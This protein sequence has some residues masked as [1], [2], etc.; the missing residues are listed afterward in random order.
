MGLR[1]SNLNMSAH[2][3]QMLR[4]REQVI[5][6]PVSG[7]IF[8]FITMPASEN[9]SRVL[10]KR[11]VDTIWRE[12]AFDANGN[13]GGAATIAAADPTPQPPLRLVK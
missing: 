3:Q 1:E 2:S 7:Y 8:K 6:D 10:F 9:P 11:T 12:Y 13:F 5:D 4:I